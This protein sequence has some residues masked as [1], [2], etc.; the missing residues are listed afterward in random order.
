MPAPMEIVA[1]LLEREREIYR[2]AEELNEL[3]SE[4]NRGETYG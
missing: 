1:S 3:L 2:I 4:N